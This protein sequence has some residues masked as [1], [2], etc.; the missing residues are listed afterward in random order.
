MEAEVAVEAAEEEAKAEA[1][2]VDE[3][4]NRTTNVDQSQRRNR[5]KKPLT[6]LVMP[7]QVQNTSSPPNSS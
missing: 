7:R 2:V 5:Y 1:D 3:V 4:E 6:S